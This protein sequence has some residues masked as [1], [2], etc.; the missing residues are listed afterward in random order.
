MSVELARLTA[1]GQTTIPKRIREAAG[2]RQGDV[3]AFDL[4]GDQVRV[5]KVTGPLDEYL[6]ALQDTLHEWDSKEDEIA[7]RDL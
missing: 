7:W 4:V 1:R 5:R 3:L 2:L 6:R